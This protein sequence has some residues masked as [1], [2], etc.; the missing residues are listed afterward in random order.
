MTD[1]NYSLLVSTTWERFSVR[2]AKRKFYVER[3]N[4]KKLNDV[5]VKEYYQLKITK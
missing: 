2:R 3:S 4:F 5:E 1:T